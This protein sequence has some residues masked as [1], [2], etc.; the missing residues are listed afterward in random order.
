MGLML[1][2]L[3]RPRSWYMCS[4]Q[5]SICSQTHS[6]YTCYYP[7]DR[8]VTH[9]ETTGLCWLDGRSKTG[10]FIFGGANV[11]I[12]GRRAS[13]LV[14]FPLPSIECGQSKS[15]YCLLGQVVLHTH[16][17]THTR[18]RTRTQ[19]GVGETG[20]AALLSY[21]VGLPQPDVEGR[22]FQSV[23]GL[24]RQHVLQTELAVNPHLHQP[25]LD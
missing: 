19:R 14:G 8:A 25:H 1:K 2:S 21:L 24:L 16:T 15:F 5:L 3:T 4:K 17:H 7:G 10:A 20:A 22:L 13:H 11:T 12:K 18:T 6:Y 9:A 23:Y